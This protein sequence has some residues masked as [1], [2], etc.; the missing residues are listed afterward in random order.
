MEL[1]QIQ[2]GFDCSFVV[3]S[4]GISGPEELLSHGRAKVNF[5]WTH[6]HTTISFKNWHV[7]RLG[8]ILC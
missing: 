1:V 4:G 8:R 5:V 3:N 7:E 2:L 6:F